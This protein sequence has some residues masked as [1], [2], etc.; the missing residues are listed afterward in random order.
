MEREERLKRCFASP[1]DLAIPKLK[2]I[3]GHHGRGLNTVGRKGD[4]DG[5]GIFG[6]IVFGC[7]RQFLKSRHFRTAQFQTDAAALA[8]RKVFLLLCRTNLRP[9]CIMH[10]RI[11]HRHIMQLGCNLNLHVFACFIRPIRMVGRELDSNVSAGVGA[12]CERQCAHEN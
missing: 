3:V 9:P 2:E 4:I 1:C 5:V 10:L 11:G 6:T 8:H 7:D 12:L